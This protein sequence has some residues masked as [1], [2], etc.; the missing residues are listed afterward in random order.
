MIKAL[1]LSL[2]A[3]LATFMLLMGV[4]QLRIDK[5]EIKTS[6]LD[7]GLEKVEVRGLDLRVDEGYQLESGAS[8]WIVDKNGMTKE[9]IA[10]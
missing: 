6:L 9:I 2:S 1:L 10:N 3:G 5:E 7:V 8:Y 4:N